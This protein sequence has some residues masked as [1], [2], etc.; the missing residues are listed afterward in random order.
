VKPGIK[1]GGLVGFAVWQSERKGK[2]QA[3]GTA[4]RSTTS[5]KP[6]GRAPD[7]VRRISTEVPPD[8]EEAFVVECARRGMRKFE[9]VRRVLEIIAD[10]NLFDAVLGE[11]VKP[12]PCRKPRHPRRIALDY[13]KLL[14][15]D[16]GLASLHA[17]WSA[18]GYEVT[19]ARLWRRGDGAFTAR[20]GWRSRVHACATV[21]C[22]VSGIELPGA[23]LR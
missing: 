5:T 8:V 2:E 6:P 12:H 19:S 17:T 13:E 14:A 21:I 3:R 16:A 20:I 18:A 10:D 11:R 4:R 1:Q 23:A 9:L 7:R 15:A 22:T